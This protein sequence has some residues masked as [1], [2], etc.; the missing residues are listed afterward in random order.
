MGNMKIFFGGCE[1]GGQFG[2]GIEVRKNVV[3]TIKDF[4]VIKP[5]L[6]LLEIETKWFDIVLM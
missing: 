3:S 1:E 6:E 5:R 4:R 2:V